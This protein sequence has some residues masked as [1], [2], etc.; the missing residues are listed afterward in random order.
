MINICNLEAYKAKGKVLI[1]DEID[2]MVRNHMVYFKKRAKETIYMTGL[3]NSTI[4]DK[5]FMATSTISKFE[6]RYL[7][8]IHSI[9]PKDI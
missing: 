4:A 2:S 5:V 9:A 3:I 8:K 1:L 7:S 6:L